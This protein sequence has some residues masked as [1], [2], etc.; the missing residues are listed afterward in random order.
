MDEVLRQNLIMEEKQTENDIY[1]N[2]FGAE[3]Q[4]E[5]YVVQ[6]RQQISATQWELSFYDVIDEIEHI[7]RGEVRNREG[8][9]E[10]K[11]DAQGNSFRLL[12]DRGIHDIKMILNA[13]VNKNTF[14]TVLPEERVYYFIRTFRINIVSLLAMNHRSYDLDRK[15]RDYI[16]EMITSILASAFFRA[17]DGGEAKRRSSTTINRYTYGTI[18]RPHPAGEKRGLLGL[19][20]MGL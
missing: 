18:D 14:L 11:E 4:V 3:Q 20:F 8:V 12:N 7:L 10:A 5:S 16:V 2:I 6:E 13:L 1:K 17:Q 19:G 15:Y 9:W